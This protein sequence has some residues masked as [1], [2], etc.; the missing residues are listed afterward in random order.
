M[1]LKKLYELFIEF[2]VAKTGKS[3]IPLT[4]TTYEKY[5]DY[6]LN[7][8][9]SK[10]RSDVCDFCHNNKGND[11]DSEVK[12]HKLSVENY[13]GLKKRFLEE[14]DV[15]CLEFDFGQNLGLPKIPISDQFYKRLI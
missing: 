11:G 14:N 10:L 13:T 12:S 8:A 3:E 5:F 6:N 1:T 15:L 4:Q 7:F 2:Y 9:F